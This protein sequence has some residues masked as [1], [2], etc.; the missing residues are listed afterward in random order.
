M[1]KLVVFISIP[2]VITLSACYLKTP[3]RPVPFEDRVPV[4]ESL[5]ITDSDPTTIT[6]ARPA[7][8]TAGEPAPTVN[9]YIGLDGDI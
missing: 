7:F 9:A 3:W 1:K 2:L 8:S 5:V 6:L 4:L